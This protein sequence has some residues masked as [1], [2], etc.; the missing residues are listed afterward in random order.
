[1]TPRPQKGKHRKRRRS[2]HRGPLEDQR[3]HDA[4]RKLDNP[5]PDRDT[6]QAQPIHERN[7]S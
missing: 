1:M 5:H 3:F 2:W 6:E 7:E 4:V